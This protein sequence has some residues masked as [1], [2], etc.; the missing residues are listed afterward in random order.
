MPKTMRCTLLSLRDLLVSAGPFIL[1]AV[2]LLALAYWWLDPMPPKQVT[3]ATG[4]AQSAYDEFGKRYVRTLAAQGIEVRLLPSEGAAQ[5]LQWLREGR[6]D[7]GFVQGGSMA[8]ASDDD[9][10]LASLGSLFVE[11]VWLFYRTASARR[12]VPDATLQALGQLKGLRVN[13]G[14]QGSGVPSLMAKLFDSNHIDTNAI[15]LTR[16][17]Q[18]PATVA[19]LNGELDA[20]VFA[21]APESLM[22]QMLLQT[23]GIKLMNFA[24]SEA[25][26]R[27]F[28]FLTPVTLPRGVVD[29]AADVPPQDVRLIAPTTTLLARQGVH[30]ALMQLFSQASLN[31]HGQAGWFNRTNEFPNLAHTEFALAREAQRTVRDGVPLLQRYL[32][33][34]LAN[35]MERMWLALGIIIA[36]LL[37]LGRIV[38]PLYEFR[39]RSRVFRW[40][41]QLREIENRAST[42]TESAQAL[43]DALNRLETRA[44]RINIPLSYADELYALRDH[45]EQVRRR[46]LNS[47]T[48]IESESS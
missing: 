27:R 42:G 19:L 10:G 30:P 12:V 46:L 22:V 17:E 26:S 21:S 35:L 23:P 43:V 3:L 38:P 44:G 24:Q 18:T 14:T 45:I 34:T 13:V 41:G 11:P 29:L 16:L 32:P 40:Y 25:Y 36:V 33:F 39:I 6:A 4:P 15:T 2:V 8:S 5:N 28:A 9:E 48:S 7:F 31:L 1:L 37:P 20:L 47:L